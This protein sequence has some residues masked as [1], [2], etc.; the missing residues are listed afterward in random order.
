[1]SCLHGLKTPA[2]WAFILAF[3]GLSIPLRADDALNSWQAQKK[4]F[5]N[6]VRHMPVLDKHRVEDILRVRV[7]NNCL[8]IRTPLSNTAENA[9]MQA[10]LDGITGTAL[11]L[12]QR[13]NGDQ[14]AGEVEPFSFTLS[15][16]DYTTPKQTTSLV[17]NSAYEQNQ[18]SISRSLQ[19]TDGRFNQVILTQQHSPQSSGGGL[20]R[21]IVTDA[22]VAGAAPTQLN[23]EAP[24]F[25]S[26][27][28]EHPQEA[29][30]YLRPLLREVGQE[31]VFAPEP[32]VAWQIFSDL[33]TPDPQ[34]TKKV[35]HLL[36]RLDDENYR[37]RINAL[38]K[39]HNLG[40]D[41]AAVMVHMDR[42]RLSPEQNML[43]DRALVQY[44]QLPARDAARLRSDP[45][46]LLDCL[47]SEDIT[48]RRA[49]LSRLNKIAKGN[50]PFDVT[51]DAVTRAR[52]VALL[53]Q[54]LLGQPRGK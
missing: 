28:R 25:F 44:A 2:T 51:A 11:V 15:I 14:A 47:Y 1:M 7:Q 3:L 35:Q 22:K 37:I 5:E 13:K 23:F 42:T 16:T 49:A 33:W 48:I 53:R 54:Q 38:W 24:D 34:V 27:L 52:A 19:F 43:I 50:L 45:A 41:G 20:L 8:V 12:V 18:F 26:F 9:F 32:M 29:N 6:L 10:H 36:P 40:T 31:S 17:I 4:T 39:L 46:F 30:Q 21:L